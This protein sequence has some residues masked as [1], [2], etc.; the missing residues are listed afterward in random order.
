MLFVDDWEADSNKEWQEFFYDT[1]VIVDDTTVAHGLKFGIVE[2]G[3]NS[4]WQEIINFERWLTADK[5]CVAGWY[6]SQITCGPEPKPICTGTTLH[7][8]CIT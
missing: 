3:F 1:K 7:K 2:D 6:K 5:S 4:Q 8:L